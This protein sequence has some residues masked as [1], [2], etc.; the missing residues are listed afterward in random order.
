M[1]KTKPISKERIAEYLTKQRKYL[2]TEEEILEERL[3]AVKEKK[4]LT[5]KVL[6]RIKPTTDTKVNRDFFIRLYRKGQTRNP[7]L[8]SMQ[9]LRKRFGDYLAEKWRDKAYKLG[10]DK[11]DFTRRS[12][13]HRIQFAGR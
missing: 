2:L 10:K 4:K 3:K 5:E 7:G 1:T 6:D 8:I 12:T 11:T 13:G 9:K